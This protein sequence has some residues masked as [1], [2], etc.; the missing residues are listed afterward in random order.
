MSDSTSTFK[1]FCG[2]LPHHIVTIVVIVLTLLFYGLQI[3]LVFIL[4]P[5][6]PNAMIVA[7]ASPGKKI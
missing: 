2:N 6:S 3:A 1:T 5:V 7:Y 4:F